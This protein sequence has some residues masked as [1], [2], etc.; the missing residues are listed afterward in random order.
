MVL[1][2]IASKTALIVCA[3]LLICI[4]AGIAIAEFALHPQQLQPRLISWFEQHGNSQLH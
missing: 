3:Y 2:K 4:V 1:H